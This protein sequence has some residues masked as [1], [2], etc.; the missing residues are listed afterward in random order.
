MSH[1]IN[2]L[3]LLNNQLELDLKMIMS[4]YIPYIRKLVF[5]ELSVGYTKE[6][7]EKYLRDVFLE[8]LTY[9]DGINSE[10]SFNKVLLEIIA[11]RKVIDM[12]RRI[13]NNKILIDDVSVDLHNISYDVIHSILLKEG[14]SQLID[15]IKSLDESDSE[16]ITRKYY[17]NQRLR[18]I[19]K[20]SGLKVSVYA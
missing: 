11:K 17:L 12:N 18:D 3:E 8:V 9:K 5:N 14:N 15:D 13:K 16:A 6:D 2:L 7:I 20:N 10:S 19:S 4:K 1:D